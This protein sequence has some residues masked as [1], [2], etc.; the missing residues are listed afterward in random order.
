MR[1]IKQVGAI[2]AATLMACQAQGQA[3]ARA[4]PP[5]IDPVRLENYVDGLTRQAMKA[6]RIAGVTVA[7]VQNGRPILLKGFGL[8]RLDPAIPVDPRHTLFRIGSLSKT[9]TWIA[10]MQQVEQKRL[11]L[12]APIDTYLPPSLRTADTRF[13]RP[14]RVIDLM[15][16]AGGYENRDVGRLFETD[17]GKLMSSAAYLASHRPER[18]RAPGLFPTYSNYGTEL[19]AFAA[20]RAAGVPFAALVERGITGPLGMG[21]TTFREPY[22]S[23]PDLPAPMAPL[24]AARVS[25]AFVWRGGRFQP[26]PFEHILVPAAGSV[27][28]TAA[29][30]ATYML[31]QLGGGALGSQRIY[32][33]A[34]AAAFRTPVFKRPAGS[35]GWAHGFQVARYPGGHDSYGHGGATQFFRTHMALVPSLELGV[36]VSANTGSADRFVTGFAEQIVQQFYAPNPELVPAPVIAFAAEAKRYDGSYMSTRRAYSGI[37]QVLGYLIGAGTVSVSPDGQLITRTSSTKRWVPGSAAGV[38]LSVEGEGPIQFQFSPD[39]RAER[40]FTASGTTAYE[41]VGWYQTSGALLSFSLATLLIAAGILFRWPGRSATPDGGTFEIWSVRLARLV[42]VIWLASA[43]AFAVWAPSAMS[44]EATQW[45][46]G[47]LI[48]ASSAALAASIGSVGLLALL[49]PVLLRTPKAG[50]ARWRRWRRL[51]HASVVVVFLA[52]AALLAS[53]GALSPWNS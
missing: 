47:E 5:A 49:V 52:F 34:T 7:I 43:A 48:A 17:P 30:M 22:L 33:P 35:N 16:H 46:R 8:A 53:W 28:S 9:F 23:R 37:Q 4:G 26:Q 39:G 6:D 11:R 41:R 18:V 38:F 25:D 50:G 36:F 21:N 20:S 27:S 14:I 19:A 32:S 31:A 42:S 29:D 2:L 44:G 15:S 40:W 51:R 24:L 1:I 10:V 12:D 45:P 13:K 3:P